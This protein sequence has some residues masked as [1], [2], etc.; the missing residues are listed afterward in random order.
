MGVEIEA[1]AGGAT[2]AAAVLAAVAGL[3]D[4]ADL[5]DVAGLAAWVGLATTPSSAIAAHLAAGR[6]ER[7]ATSYAHTASQLDRLVRNRE[8]SNAA[9]VDA[10]EKV[11]AAQKRQLGGVAQRVTPRWTTDSNRRPP[12]RCA[13]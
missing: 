5:A 1:I 9:F 4:F 6:Y 7:L 13:I 10:I 8:T 2:G 12:A 3:A 11:L